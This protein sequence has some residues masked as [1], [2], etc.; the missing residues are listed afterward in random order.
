MELT[1]CTPPVSLRVPALVVALLVYGN[2]EAMSQAY[3]YDPP[4]CGGSYRAEQ[5]K[6]EQL[7][8]TWEMSAANECIQQSKFPL[9]CEH[10]NAALASADRMGP[11]A[12]SPD[13][14]KSYLKSMLKTNGCQK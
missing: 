11:D 13:G 5:A 1:F 7:R 9:A 2:D 12:G 4:V 6:P 10:L 14:I 8:V 3:T